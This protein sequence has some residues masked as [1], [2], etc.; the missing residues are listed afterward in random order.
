M[1]PRHLE[2]SAAAR[3][4][5]LGPSELRN[6]DIEAMLAASPATAGDIATADDAARELLSQLLS[7]EPYVI[8]HGGYRGELAAR[9]ERLN[10]AFDRMEQRAQGRE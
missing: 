6:E 10:D 4:D 7:N 3:P 5:A 2:S 8:T 9:H 1:I